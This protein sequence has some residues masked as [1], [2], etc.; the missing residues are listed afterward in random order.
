MFETTKVAVV[1]Y[2]D[3][4]MR[5][6]V[7]ASRCPVWIVNSPANDP[8]I[9]AIWQSGRELPEGSGVTSF[10]NSSGIAPQQKFLSMLGT[11]DLHHYEWTAL[12]VY[13]VRC[14]AEVRDALE[15]FG[16]V[17]IEEMPEFFVARR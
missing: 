16:T 10:R 12:E 2:E 17:T 9:Q 15:A 11:I 1:L 13:G 8:A 3:F 4:G 14:D 7:L 5:L 6:E